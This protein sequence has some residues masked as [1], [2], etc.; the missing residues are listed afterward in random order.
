MGTRK[1]KSCLLALQLVP[2]PC[3]WGI[4][5]FNRSMPSAFSFILWRFLGC[6]VREF[7]INIPGVGKEVHFHT[8]G[9]S[10]VLSFPGASVKQCPGSGCFHFTLS[11]QCLSSFR[12][13]SR[14][15]CSPH[16]VDSIWWGTDKEQ[17]NRHIEHVWW[18]ETLWQKIKQD[19]G[20]R[21]SQGGRGSALFWE[22]IW[23]ETEGLEGWSWNLAP[24]VR[25]W[26]HVARTRTQPKSWLGFE[27]TWL[28]LEPG[29]NP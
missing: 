14:W 4:L 8:I 5:G 20:E 19:E 2:F 9:G 26:T 15:Y 24:Q 27:P 17:V 25:T 3:S 23:A 22:D 21:W 11:I 7:R 13:S 1:R 29:Q 28:G 18:R 16:R 6:E 10:R 12:Q